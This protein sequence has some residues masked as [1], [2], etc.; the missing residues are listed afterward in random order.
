MGDCEWDP[1]RDAAAAWDLGGCPLQAVWSLGRGIGNNWHLCEDCA[2]LPRF[3]SYRHRVRIRPR[4]DEPIKGLLGDLAYHY[5]VLAH[6]PNLGPS[7]RV[8][9]EVQAELEARQR[10]L[11]ALRK[12]RKASLAGGQP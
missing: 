5:D 3:A 1:E 9:Q 4:H 8:V 11:D 10:E 2:A 6:V 12:L 7:V